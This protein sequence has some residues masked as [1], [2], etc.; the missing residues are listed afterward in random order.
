MLSILYYI[1]SV[2]C[3]LHYIIGRHL[4]RSD[5]KGDISLS[6]YQYSVYNITYTIGYPV[7]PSK[8]SSVYDYYV[9]E[10]DI[11]AVSTHRTTSVQK[12][13]NYFSAF[14]VEKWMRAGFIWFYSI[15]CCIY[16]IYCIVVII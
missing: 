12:W 15:Y 1:T 16:C 3:T 5:E 10:R 2:Y 7:F 13:R 4:H 11:V 9:R 8:L 6:S 14:V